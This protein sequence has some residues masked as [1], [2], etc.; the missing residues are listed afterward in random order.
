MWFAAPPLRLPHPPPLLQGPV[1]P[2]KS[3]THDNEP[4]FD[5]GDGCLFNIKC[6]H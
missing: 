4:A 2:N 3:T 6:D 5:C 1:Y